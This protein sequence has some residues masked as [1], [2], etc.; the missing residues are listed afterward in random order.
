MIVFNWKKSF[1]SKSLNC[2][3]NNC[4]CRWLMIQFK[5][6]SYWASWVN[7]IHGGRIDTLGVKLK[8]KIFVS[9]TFS[10]HFVWNCCIKP[11]YC[12]TGILKDWLVNSLFWSVSYNNFVALQFW[13]AYWD[14][15]H[16]CWMSCG[17]PW[18]II[19]VL[20]DDQVWAEFILWNNFSR[21]E[22]IYVSIRPKCNETFKGFWG[23]EA[24]GGSTLQCGPHDATYLGGA[25]PI[26][27]EFF[28]YSRE[29]RF[30]QVVVADEKQ[31]FNLW[32]R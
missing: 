1:C 3:L 29:K 21:W 25:C 23:W 10:C 28:N 31:G 14:G 5:S 22:C 16:W 2:F 24:Y 19:A 17:N 12:A 7:D 8:V 26:G 30:K 18:F 13:N 27:S 15:E 9:C 11:A 4:E 32:V 6:R 20:T